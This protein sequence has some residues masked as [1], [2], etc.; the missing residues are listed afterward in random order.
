MLQTFIFYVKSTTEYE[1][2]KL[3]RKYFT[4]PIHIT[5]M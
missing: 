5:Q 2:F 3:E 1:G 4:V